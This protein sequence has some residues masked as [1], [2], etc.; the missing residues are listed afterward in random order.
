M[1]TVRDLIDEALTRH[2]SFLEQRTPPGAAMLFL[3]RRQRKLLLEHAASVEGLVTSSRQVAAVVPSSGGLV[4]VDAGGVPSYSTTVADGYA[5]SLD[6]SGVPYVD[7]SLAPIALDPFGASGG[8]PG[9]PLPVQFVKAV[10]ATLLFRNG[11]R[12]PLTIVR[13]G[14]RLD[15]PQ[16]RDAAAFVNGNR[17]VPVRHTINGTSVTSDL[18]SD[19]AAVSL[20]YLA[21]Q[22]F[23]ALTDVVTL[24]DT[25]VEALVAGLAEQMALAATPQHVTMGEKAMFTAAARAS[26]KELRLA[27]DRILGDLVEDSITYRP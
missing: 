10:A 12:A 17:L 9:F 2:W 19:V 23:A 13:E 4:G 22:T 14:E 24:P 3:N 21:A 6:G 15:S 26:E 11:D 1:T 25:L 16:G 5:V 8:T 7:T 27:G 20:S 18:W